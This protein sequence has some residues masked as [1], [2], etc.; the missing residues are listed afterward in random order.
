MTE[1]EARQF[2]KRLEDLCA[3]FE[4]ACK[5]RID[6]NIIERREGAKKIKWVV[7]DSI[8]LKIN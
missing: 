2:I 6:L 4:N 3:E 1:T 7:V 8:S 5:D